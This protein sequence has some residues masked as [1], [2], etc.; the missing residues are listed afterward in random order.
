MRKSLLV[1]VVVAILVLGVAGPVLA[2]SDNYLDRSS[3][4]AGVFVAAISTSVSLNGEHAGTSV[5]FENDLGL[6]G[7]TQQFWV[8]G[9]WRL[10]ERQSLVLGYTLLRRSHTKNIERQLVIDDTTYDVGAKFDTGWDT[11]YVA[12]AYR[13]SLLR[14]DSFEGGLSGGISYFGQKLSLHAE[15]TITG[16]D[17]ET[18]AEKDVA[19]TLN[20]PA[21]LVG[22]YALG[23]LSRTLYLGGSLLYIQATYDQYTGHVWDGRLSLD[24]FPWEH[25]GLGVGYL[26][27]EQSLGV[28]K[29][30]FNGDVTY[31]FD[32]AQ[33]YVRYAF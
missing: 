12:V 30:S 24:W 32:G 15:G 13:F 25:F 21:P 28:A 7:D 8:D 22:L 10:T 4:G 27:S 20:V 11:Q 26:Y 3:L 14:Y 17:G 18:Q 29:A 19:K 9:K 23:R 2:Q 16:P 31:R 1:Q 6:K 5:D 33:A